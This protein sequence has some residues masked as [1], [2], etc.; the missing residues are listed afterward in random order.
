MKIAMVAAHPNA[1]HVP[2]LAAALCRHGHDVTVYRRWDDPNKPQ[3]MRADH[4]YDIVHVPAGPRTPLSDDEALP[5]MGDFTSFLLHQWSLSTPDVVHAHRWMSGMTSVLG[6]R[7]FQAP[8]VQ[9]FHSLAAHDQHR[10]GHRCPAERG[11]IEVLVAKEAAHIIATSSSE[12]F[13]LARAGIERARISVVP[14][15]VDI[16]AFT[17]DGPQAGRTRPYRVVVAAPPPS[18]RDIDA[19]LTTLSRAGD[20]ELVLTGLPAPDDLP[21]RAQKLGVTLTGPVAPTAMPPLLRS[22][23]AVVC[24]PAHEPSSTVALEAMACG[25]PVI[26]TAVGD[27]ADIVVPGVTGLLVPPQ[28]ADG[29]ARALHTLLLDETLRQEL[30]MAS[31]DRVT[32]RYAWS[33]IALEVLGVYERAGVAAARTG[34]TPPGPALQT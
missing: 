22:S 21:A 15:G 9:T 11:K 6:A 17:P 19:I 10:P 14:S 1:A 2:G 7:R 13:T 26:A 18:R 24:A 29:L 23:D 3:Q 30:A 31:R 5:H 33:H 12:S 28:D 34:V 8:V 20:A 32:A 27:L 4:G 16:D 25:V